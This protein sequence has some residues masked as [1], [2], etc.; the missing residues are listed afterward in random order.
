MPI[1]EYWITDWDGASQ[2]MQSAVA[3]DLSHLGAHFTF[4]GVYGVE[5][6]VIKLL[7]FGQ[8]D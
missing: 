6:W 1:N 3:T 5:P 2:S 4:T 8:S 7:V